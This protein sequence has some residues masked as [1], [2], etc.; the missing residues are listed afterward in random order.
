MVLSGL[1]TRPPAKRK[2]SPRPQPAPQP[3][4][5]TTRPTVLIPFGDAPPGRNLRP[6]AAVAGSIAVLV[7]LCCG[8]LAVVT[9]LL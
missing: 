9:R 2:P 3:D 5:D 6:V 8:G 1:M 7:L 4:P